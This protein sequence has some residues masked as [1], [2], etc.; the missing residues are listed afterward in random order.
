MGG[1]CRPGEFLPRRI[2]G[3]RESSGGAGRLLVYRSPA[4]PQY[5]CAGLTNPAN[6]MDAPTV[7][8]ARAAR[9]AALW[10]A[11]VSALAAGCQDGPVPEMRYLNPWIRQQWAQDEQF[12]P[13]YHRKVADLGTLR[14][15]AKSLSPEERERVAQLVAG[16]FQDEQSPVMRVELLKTLG[17]LPS[18]TAQATVQTSLADESPQVRIAACRA[19]GRQGTSEGIAE[20]GKV[21]TADADLDVRIAAAREL[22][23]FK[24]P[25]AAQALRP[26]LDDND[27]AFQSVAMQSLRDITGKAQYANSVPAWREYLDGGNPT[28]PPPPTIAETLQKYWYWY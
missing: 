16:R 5:L 15:T 6:P 12:G 27:A 26:A 7:P 8:S 9:L 20:L 14:S 22:G 25:A 13:T 19:L 24:D 1:F 10:A 3:H 23:Q 28:P 4:A 11:L 21:I 2:V 18:P 17:E